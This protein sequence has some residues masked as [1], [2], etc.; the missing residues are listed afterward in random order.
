MSNLGGGFA[1]RWGGGGGWGGYLPPWNLTM[2][3]PPLAKANNAKTKMK[4]S[5]GA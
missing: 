1:L 2:E 4:H 5:L 3:A